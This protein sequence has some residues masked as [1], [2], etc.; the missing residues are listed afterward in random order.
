MKLPTRIINLL[1]LLQRSAARVSVQ[2]LCHLYR[3]EHT[4]RTVNCKTDIVVTYSYR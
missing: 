3:D 4:D 2:D 1:D